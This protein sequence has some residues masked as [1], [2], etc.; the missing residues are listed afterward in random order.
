MSFLAGLFLLFLR[1][2]RY[3]ISNNLLFSTEYILEWEL[4]HVMSAYVYLVFILDF[5]SVFFASLVFLISGRVIIYSTS[6]M[7]SETFYGRFVGIVL[8]FVLSMALLIFR[9]NLIS[10]LLGWDG[11]G[12]TSY[13]LVV[14]Y[15]SN[16]SY[17]AG[18]ITAL[19]N[20]LGDV[21]ILVALSLIMYIGDWTFRFT[22]DLCSHYSET[23]VILFVLSA[24]TKSAQIPFSSWLPA[25]MAAPTPVSALVHS[26]TLVTAGVYLLIRFN[27]ML[28]YRRFRHY[29]LAVGVVTILIAGFAAIY[30]TDIKKVIALSTLS[31]LGVIII[32][33]GAKKPL[34]AYFHLLSHA[35][36]KAMLF[37]CAGIVIHNM[38]D[39][40]DIRSMGSLGLRMPLITTVIS[41]ANLRLCGLPFLRGFYS[42]DLILETTILCNTSLRAFLLITLATILTVIY[43]CRLSLY[44]SSL[45]IKSESLF[46][47]AEKD[48]YIVL[49]IVFLLP[50]SVIGR[51]NIR[52]AILPS[53]RLVFM[54]L[55]IKSTILVLITFG[56]VILYLYVANSAYINHIFITYFLANIVFM[57][58]LYRA[59]RAVTSLTL[60][61]K[62]QKLSEQTW[63]ETFLYRYLASRW[64]KI[65]QYLFLIVSRY[66]INSIF[67]LVGVF[68][69]V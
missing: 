9:P 14:F 55:W 13:M 67:I 28:A 22:R 16:K 27:S 69:L 20:R 64:K 23:L 52:W 37:I 56:L 46:L 26:S 19:T 61:K 8:L 62:N 65:S 43:S 1:A 36:F 17:N 42:K 29:L 4:V 6:Y 2:A 41:I 15:Q 51:I 3:I 66:F 5:T 31:Q 49:G 32:V 63:I 54:P 34:L 38:K 30:E 60:A 68:L 21:G 40:Q 45:S 53:G 11:L 50:F 24:C 47:T 33:L 10:L 48:Y 39:Y 7:S 58:M 25:A 44:L 59:L 35:Y 57:P 18:I 12:V